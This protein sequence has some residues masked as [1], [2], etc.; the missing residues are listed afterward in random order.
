MPGFRNYLTTKLGKLVIPQIESPNFV[1]GSTG[2]R[3][4]KNGSAEFHSISLPAGSA[5]PVVT[6]ASS[7]P[8]SPNPGDVWYDTS[9]GLEA[10]VWSGSAWTPYQ[11][12]TQAIAAGSI[13]GA[14]LGPLVTARSLGGNIT[15]I[16]SSAPGS[17]VTG[18]LWLDSSSGYQMK[19]WNGSAWTAIT[20]T[21]SSVIAA[22]TITATQIAAATITATQLAAGIVYAGIVNGT[23]INAA[24]F[25]GSVFKGTDFELDT[26][27]EFFYSGTPALGNL[28]E[29]ITQISGTDAY[30]NAY[31]TGHASYFK[32][33]SSLWYAIAVD[34]ATYSAPVVAFLTAT[35][36][37]GPWTQLA[38]ILYKSLGAPGPGDVIALNVDGGD[39]AYITTNGIQIP[40]AELITATDPGTSNTPE[41]WHNA[42]LINGWANQ[43]GGLD[44][45]QYKLMPDNSIWLKGTISPAAQ[46]N[47]QFMTLPA[48]YRPFTAQDI[49]V[50]FHTA[51]GAGQGAF[52]RVATS[53]ACS[54]LNST[55]TTGA[56][57]VNCRIPLDGA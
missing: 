54:I 31:L 39:R 42:T 11:I 49:G 21:G 1:H 44:T 16:A 12:G 29:S 8:L 6:F 53:G 15:T 50:G 24:T 52:L 37:A 45:L 43:G 3:I 32:V 55:T 4:A 56:V 28:V 13:T 47:T 27:G 46:T 38:N 48:G 20:W 14:L 51:T 23:T 2:W 17:P 35:S 5:G 10:K 33:S 19:Q 57:C 18:D 26:N 22:G 34:A 9:N 7:A 36:P 41:T 30:G 40:L 25:T